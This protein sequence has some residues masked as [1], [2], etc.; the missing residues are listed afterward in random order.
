[1][2]YECQM[3]EWADLVRVWGY[4]SF[5]ADMF[6]KNNSGEPV[7]PPWKPQRWI[8]TDGVNERAS[9]LIW[10]WGHV[11]TGLHN[12]PIIAPGQSA[13]WT[14]MAFPIERN[15]WVTAAE[16]VWQDQVYRTEFE[17]GPLGNAYNYKDCGEY[18]PTTGPRVPVPVA[19]TAGPGPG[20]GPAGPT[21]PR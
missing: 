14:F 13:G 19:P 17:L 8:I 9:D 2:H 20:P 11:Q 6:I 1:M 7:Q 4:R 18:P 3:T 21:P 10:E 15:E 5:Q 16:F 12:Q